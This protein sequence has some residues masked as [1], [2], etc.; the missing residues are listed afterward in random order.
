MGIE[1]GDL[2][3]QGDLAEPDAARRPART[4]ARARSAATD[5]PRRQRG[6]GAEER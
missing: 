6:L 4:A 3:V 2:G 5:S 1:R